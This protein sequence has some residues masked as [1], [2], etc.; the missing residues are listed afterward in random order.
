[1]LKQKRNHPW[2]KWHFDFILEINRMFFLHWLSNQI[3]NWIFLLEAHFSATG[4]E[5]TF[6]V[7]S[8]VVTSGALGSVWPLEIARITDT[9][10]TENIETGLISKNKEQLSLN[11]IWFLITTVAIVSYTF[12][13]LF[14]ILYLIVI[15]NV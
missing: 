10:G 8:S 3:V 1:M 15:K 11:V 13:T 5:R 14:W 4:N 2:K 12:E 7:V 9:K 6:L